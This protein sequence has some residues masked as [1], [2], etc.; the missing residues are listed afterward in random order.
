MD[1]VTGGRNCPVNF[2][3]HT[4]QL[5]LLGIT[6]LKTLQVTHKNSYRQMLTNH[7]WSFVKIVLI[8]SGKTHFNLSVACFPGT[9][10][11]TLALF[12]MQLPLSAP[13]LHTE[14][15]SFS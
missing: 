11:R 15:S 4:L 9:S 12:H 14:M 6:N 8:F 5:N 2:N 1:V 3:K 13:H 10:Q 7:S